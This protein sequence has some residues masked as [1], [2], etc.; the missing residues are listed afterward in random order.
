MRIFIAVTTDIAYDQR[1]LRIAGSLQKSG[2]QVKVFGRRKGNQHQINGAFDHHLINCW[3][4]KS[5]LFYAEYNLRLFFNLIISKFDVVCACDLDTMIAS[6]I[7]ASL[8][9]KILVFDAHEYME[10][11][12]ELIHKKS[13]K[14]I[15]E[16]IARICIPYA[17]LCYTVSQ[18]LANELST[19]YGRDFKLIRNVPQGSYVSHAGPRQKIIWYQGA[20]NEGRGLECMIECMTTLKNY[21]LFLA[22]DGDLR[23]A[24]HNKVRLLKLESRILF[25]GR[26]NYQEM[27]M[28]ASRS[29]IGID[30]LESVSKS[31]YLSLSNK[32]FDY[33]HVGL[34]SIQMSF[35]EYREIHKQYRTGVLIESIKKE[36][37]LTAIQQLEDPDYYSTCTDACKE[38]SKLFNWEQEEGTLIELYGSIRNG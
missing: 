3:F 30:L 23:I 6:T 11:S 8:K 24:L 14:R 15:W 10:E 34:P 20:I 18:S 5:I 1:I 25:L 37:I 13:V 2:H 29:Y 19:K 35:P 32:T 28:H 9:K 27:S 16:W 21:S 12:I 7:A 17:K 22:G 38:A 36:T 31:Y 4:S 26:L 33:I